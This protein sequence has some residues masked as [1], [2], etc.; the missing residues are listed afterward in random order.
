M[1]LLKDSFLTKEKSWQQGNLILVREADD[2]ENSSTILNGIPDS[3]EDGYD[4][5]KETYSALAR[6]F[7]WKVDGSG[8][9]QEL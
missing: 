7:A 4:D 6:F 5:N 1:D 8:I 2:I 3:K 9:P